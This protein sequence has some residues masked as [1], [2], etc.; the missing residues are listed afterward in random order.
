MEKP[1]CLI[2][3]VPSGVESMNVL[4][5]SLHHLIKCI[6]DEF[7]VHQSGTYCEV[8]T[9]LNLQ[10]CLLDP[11][12]KGIWR[13]WREFAIKK[14]AA[15]PE[16][17]GKKCGRHTREESVKLRQIGNWMGGRFQNRPEKPDFARYSSYLKTIFVSQKPAF[18]LI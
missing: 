8:A 4:P 17:A 16:H 6:Q 3:N 14:R 1:K 5:P 12:K 13:M 18:S 11:A 2:S 7:I 10:G 9:Y 15:Q